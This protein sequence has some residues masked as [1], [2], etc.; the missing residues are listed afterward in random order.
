MGFS[1]KEELVRK[2]AHFSGV[3]WVIVSYYFTL[4]HTILI[5]ALFFFISLLHAV[6]HKYLTRIP[7]IGSI[8]D[9][10][11]SMSRKEE[12][13]A[14]IYYGAVYFFGTLL[15]LLYATQS[16]A[17][18][19]AAALVLIFGDAFSAIFGK[20]F[21]K[22]ELPYNPYKSVEGTLAGFI[23]A[24]VAASFVLPI[25]LAFFAAFIGTFVESLPW[26]LN[27]NLTIPLAVGF[28]L[29]ILIAL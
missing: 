12:R 27:D 19:R 15:V 9:F 28:F 8:A 7:V 24:A 20:A 13:D 5:L 3:A 25:P 14:K 29:W 26:D 18:F 2:A 22:T 23:A 11:H 1:L 10:F 6:L 21:G 4:R 16:L 17:I